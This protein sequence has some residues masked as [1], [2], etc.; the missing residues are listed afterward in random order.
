MK[1]GLFNFNNLLEDPKPK[2]GNRIGDWAHPQSP[3]I[4]FYYINNFIYK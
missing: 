1:T 2:S 3:T 4:N